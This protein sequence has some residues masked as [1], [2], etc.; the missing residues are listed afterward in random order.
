MLEG[1]EGVFRMNMMGKRV[2]YAAR[3]V[4][5]PDPYI[6]IN[7]IGIPM[8]F[9]KKLTYPEPVSDWNYLKL[10]QAIKNGPDIHPGYLLLILFRIYVILCFDKAF[11]DFYCF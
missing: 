1:K 8:I 6:N 10:K 3:S 7:E 9:A 2:N 11:E 5:A 4:I